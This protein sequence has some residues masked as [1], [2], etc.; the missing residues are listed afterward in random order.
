[1]STARMPLPKR[2]GVHHTPSTP[3][4]KTPSS[5]S[6]PTHTYAIYMDESSPSHALEYSLSSMLS[7]Q[8]FRS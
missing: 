4:L 2:R 5:V 7:P 8:R 6:A 3:S 1:M